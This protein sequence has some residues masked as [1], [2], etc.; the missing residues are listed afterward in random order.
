MQSLRA[1]RFALSVIRGVDALAIT[2][3]DR[4]AGLTEWKIATHYKTTT[5]AMRSL[6]RLPAGRGGM[7]RDIVRIEE[8]ND[9]LNEDLAR[10]L[11]RAAPVYETLVLPTSF[12]ADMVHASGGIIEKIEQELGVGV[13]LLGFGP[14]SGEKYWR[15]PLC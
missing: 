9:E 5:D 3:I 12:G 4:L 1:S 6:S 13:A 15:K 2:N 7:A 14:T 11:L 8:D 10:E